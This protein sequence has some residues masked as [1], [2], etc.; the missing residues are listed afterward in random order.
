MNELDRFLAAE[1]KAAII[2]AQGGLCA[3]CGAAPAIFLAHRIPQTKAN[4]RRYG[5]AVIHHSLNLVGVCSNPACNDRVLIDG[6]PEEKRRLLAQIRE[7]RTIEVRH[8]L[9]N[10]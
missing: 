5:R 1:Q 8:F 7:E 4:L 10:H 3:V 2:E 9:R 6:K